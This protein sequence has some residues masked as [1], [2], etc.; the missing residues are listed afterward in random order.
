MPSLP[1][2]ARWLRPNVAQASGREV[3]LEG[4]LG[5]H[6]AS[7][8]SP[9]RQQPAR[10]LQI[11]PPIAGLAP[12]LRPRECGAAHSSAYIGPLPVVS[13]AEPAWP[14][15]NVER[16]PTA[17]CYSSTAAQPHEGILAFGKLAVLS[18]LGYGYMFFAPASPAR[19]HHIFATLKG[20][21]EPRCR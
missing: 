8:L 3:H 5:E 1:T 21:R 17:N 9:T 2:P 7:A 6:P 18:Q 15:L 16:T 14:S 11:N 12:V 19:T 20:G 13:G 4:L 10:L